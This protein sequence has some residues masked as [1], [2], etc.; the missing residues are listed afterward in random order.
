M[1][2][3]QPT[4][5]DTIQCYKCNFFF[6]GKIWLQF[7]LMSDN[8]SKASRM[9]S[10]IKLHLH[11]RPISKAFHSIILA[12]VS[13][14]KSWI[15]MSHWITFIVLPFSPLYQHNVENE[16]KHSILISITPVVLKS[17][18]EKWHIH[19]FKLMCSGPKVG[20][21]RS[22]VRQ[23]CLHLRNCDY[24]LTETLW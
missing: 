17:K 23:L 2:T 11:Y 7:D 21:K 9:S 18:I 6:P 20:K 5:M 12:N 14:S 16:K 3:F 8:K 22:R 10:L 19:L 1:A 4:E 13:Y 24:G 15:L